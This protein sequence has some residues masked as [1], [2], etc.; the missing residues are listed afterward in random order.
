MTAHAKLGASSAHRWMNCPGSIRMIDALPT[1]LS[2]RRSNFY[3]DQGTAAHALGAECLSAHEGGPVLKD[4]LG[5]KIRVDPNTGDASFHVGDEPNTEG[6]EFFEVDT[7]MTDAVQVYL[8]EIAA[9]RRRLPHADTCVEEP[10]DVT[11]LRPNMFGTSD[12][13]LR[14]A[15]GELVVT[16]YKHG[17]GVV[18]DVEW[19][20]QM[21]YYG[22]GA[23]KNAGGPMDVSSVTLVIVQPRA[24]HRDG[25]VR[26]WTISSNALWDWRNQLADAADKTLAPDAALNPGDWCRFC[27]A[28]PVCPAVKGYVTKQ[29]QVVFSNSPLDPKVHKPPMP[30]MDQVGRALNAIPVIDSWCR[31]VEGLGQQMLERG[32]Q[33]DGYKLVRKRANRR[34][35]D[36]EKTQRAL[37]RIKGLKKEEF[38]KDPALLSPAQMEKLSL[39]GKDFVSKHSEKPEGGLTVAH[40]SDRRAEIEAPAKQAFT[41]VESGE[42][43]SPAKV[44]GDGLVEWTPFL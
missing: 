32:L 41:Q 17:A 36:P 38:V 16:D 29:A 7:D 40:V 21:M 24:L 20:A 2:E 35:T 22:L 1:Q 14:E 9:Q 28:Q 31:S 3:A 42:V 37:S 5:M 26:P 27:P 34:W 12:F 44:D 43:S 19:N 4:F 10:L 33:V 6:P 39:V 8:D 30:D 18:V 15:F 11:W 25:P 23:L 13:T